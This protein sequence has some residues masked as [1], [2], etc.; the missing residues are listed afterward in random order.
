MTE[1]RFIEILQNAVEKVRSEED[2]VEL[3]KYR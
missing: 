2:P 1:E 3:N